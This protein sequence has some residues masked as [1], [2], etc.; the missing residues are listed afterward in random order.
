[1]AATAI[2]ESGEVCTSNWKEAGAEYDESDDHLVIMGKPVM[3]RWETPYMHQLADIAASKGGRVLEIG[4]GMAIS[5]SRVQTHNIDEHVIIECNDG[6]FERLQKFASNATHKVT[7]LKGLWQDVVST[8]PDESFDGIL[9]DTYPLTEETWHTHQFE[10]IKGHAARLLKPGGVLTYCN[11]TSWGEYLKEKYDDIEK[12]FVETQIPTLVECGFKQ[13]KV[14]WKVM[15]IK[16]EETCRYYS[17]H[18]MI[19]PTIIKD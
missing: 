13:E 2:F 8:L 7:P 19:A 4:F 5:A 14:S 16:P 17:Y 1:M 18:K 11:L 15:D 10:F 6:V 12:M 9:Y 3:E